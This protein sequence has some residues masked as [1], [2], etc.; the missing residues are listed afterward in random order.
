MAPDQHWLAHFETQ[1]PP[2][3]R[4]L[5]FSVQFVLPRASL[6]SIGTCESSYHPV[7][8]QKLGRLCE[9]M[10]EEGIYEYIYIYII[11]RDFSFHEHDVPVL[12]NHIAKTI[13]RYLTSCHL[14]NETLENRLIQNFLLL[15]SHLFYVTLSP[16]YTVTSLWFPSVLYTI[17]DS[18]TRPSYIIV[19]PPRIENWNSELMW[20]CSYSCWYFL[21]PF[22][23]ELE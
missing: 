8:I 11:R 12:V 14:A 16:L 18:I 7:L 13:S 3:G 23:Q 6:E 4:L 19:H 2:H 20:V 22:R 21:C 5:N 9:L 15:C 17:Q 10:V 1:N